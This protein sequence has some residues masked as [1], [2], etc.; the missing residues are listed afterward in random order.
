MPAPYTPQS[1]YHATIQVPVDGDPGAEATFRGPFQALA[2]NTAWLRDQRTGMSDQWRLNQ[3]VEAYLNPQQRFVSGISNESFGPYI[4]FNGTYFACGYS[5]KPRINYS[6]DGKA[7][8]QWALTTSDGLAATVIDYTTEADGPRLFVGTDAGS[9]LVYTVT[10]QVAPT[11]QHQT[12]F[13]PPSGETAAYY[14]R[15]GDTTRLVAIT[16]DT[17]GGSNAPQ[18]FTSDDG[19]SWTSRG[20]MRLG[21]YTQPL[22]GFVCGLNDRGK[23]IMVVATADYASNAGMKLFISGDIDALA[24]TPVPVDNSLLT[25]GSLYYT[26][27]AALRFVGMAQALVGSTIENSLWV[28]DDALTWRRA[29]T[30]STA[31]TVITTPYGILISDGAVT[32]FT[33]DAVNFATLPPKPSVL[34]GSG[35]LVDAGNGQSILLLDG[36]KG[37]GG[38]DATMYTTYSGPRY[39]PAM[40]L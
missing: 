16:T 40:L 10:P 35:A 30:L 8:L 17:A 9:T 15:M 32:W 12:S 2:D 39:A 13:T 24:W 7:W 29:K 20:T 31:A 4:G 18:V 11:L 5:D 14:V 36:T 28:S 27:L 37:G 34:R 38:S 1:S 3:I 6:F 19:A 33:R 26:G 23:P 22:Q 25:I 21:S